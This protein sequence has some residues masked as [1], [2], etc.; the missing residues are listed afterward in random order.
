MLR[1]TSGDASGDAGASGPLVVHVFNLS[2]S[3][4][5]FTSQWPV[6]IGSIFRFAM[7]DKRQA[8]SRVEIRHCRRRPDGL[9]DAGGQFC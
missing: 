6:E 7:C 9:F 1:P 5:G 8:G 4:V 3:G 2:I